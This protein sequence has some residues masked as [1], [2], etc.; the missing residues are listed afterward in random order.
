MGGQHE[1]RPA[2]ARRGGRGERRA[3]SQAPVDGHRDHAVEGAGAGRRR[4]RGGEQSEQD[5]EDG[6][7][8]P[9]GASRVVAIMHARNL[10]GRTEMHTGSDDR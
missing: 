8:A 6:S 4:H 3:R 5:E 2:R 7:H 10:F 9:C 1:R